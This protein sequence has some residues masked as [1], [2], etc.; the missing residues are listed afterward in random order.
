MA[1]LTNFSFEFFYKLEIFTED[2]SQPLLYHG[3]KKSKMT[4]NSNQGGSCLKEPAL[5]KV[6]KF[7]YMCIEVSGLFIWQNNDRSRTSVLM[8]HLRTDWS[9]PCIYPSH[10]LWLAWIRFCFLSAFSFCFRSL[11]W[12]WWKNCDEKQR[13][14]LVILVYRGRWWLSFQSES[15]DRVLSGSWE[16]IF[17]GKLF[18]HFGFKD[19]GS[20]CIVVQWRKLRALDQINSYT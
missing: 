5:S 9:D 15:L 8:F 3:A 10:I 13:I 2:A 7:M 16:I 6:L 4:K 14:K 19:F 17:A 18:E 1:H 20:Y 12:D 11:A